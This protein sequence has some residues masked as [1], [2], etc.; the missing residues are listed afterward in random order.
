MG[1]EER[2]FNNQNN[3]M[4]KKYINLLL[5]FIFNDTELN[6]PETLSA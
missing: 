4:F 1:N 2:K 3:S 6:M 5:V